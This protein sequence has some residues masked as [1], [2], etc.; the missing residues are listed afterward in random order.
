MPASFRSH[1][2]LTLGVVLLMTAPVSFVSAQDNDAE[3]KPVFSL[4]TRPFVVLTAASA[5]RFRDAASLVFEAAEMPDTVGAIMEKLDENVNGLQGL[6]WDRPGGVMIFLNSVFPPS[7]EFVA[8]LPI[9]S[10]DEF[11]SMMEIGTVVMRAEPN[12]EGR[13]E[14]ITPQRNLQIRIQGDYAFIQ[15]PPMDPDPAFD[16]ELP[17]PLTLTAAL[18]RQ[19]DA[20][21]SL[22]VEAVPKPTRDLILNVVSSMMATQHQQRD[23]ES[24]VVYAVRDAWQQRDMAGLKLFFQDTQR[25]TIGVSLDREQG[26]ANLDLVLDAREASQMLEDI[27]LSSTKASYFTPLVSDESPLS[28]SYSAVAAERDR[29]A[30]ADTVEAAKGLLAMVIEQ[31]DL[32]P[33]PEESSS[34]FIAMSAVRKTLKEGHLDLFGQFYRDATDKL[35]VVAAMRVEDGDAVAAGLE[36]LLMRLQGRDEIGE[37]EIGSDQHAGI[38]FHRLEFRNP[39]AGALELFGSHPGVVLGCGSR[40]IWACVGGDASFATLTG[41]IDELEAAYENPVEREVP[42][43]LRVVINFTEFKGLIDGAGEANRAASQP[44]A[45]DDKAPK[46]DVRPERAAGRE[47]SAPPQFR[48]EDRRRQWRERRDA[49]NRML[50]ETLAEGEDRIRLDF[51]PTDKGMRFRAHFDMGFVRAFGRI[52]GSR[53]AED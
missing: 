49:N 21:V 23:D 47:G 30:A 9:S 35:V 33:V 13:Y 52:V 48:P 3:S 38:K 41:L 10:P 34:L 17:D 36:D 7:F 24:D 51:R 11:Q 6:N 22:D 39:D 44:D 32:G 29:D 8:F 2:T 42:A 28:V 4:G 12:Q 45:V 31:Q 37:V 14:L 1:M 53:L 46:E 50:L 19:Y 40:T 16:R 18:A 27:F 25:I 26:G 20:A 43:S 5:N 15:L